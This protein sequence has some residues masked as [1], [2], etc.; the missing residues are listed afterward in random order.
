MTL[1][2]ISENISLLLLSLV[3]FFLLLSSSSAF[4]SSSCFCPFFSPSTLLPLSSY[5]CHSS[6]FLSFSISFSFS[7]LPPICPSS[8]SSLA[9]VP[10]FFCSTLLFSSSFLP[11][12]HEVSSFPHCVILLHSSY[13]AT[14][15]RS[16]HE[17]KLMKLCIKIINLSAFKPFSSDSDKN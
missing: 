6:S 5:L 2:G 16:N 8:S 13:F 7:P 12:Y 14:V 10:I 3:L 11:G 17:L 4:P 1:K 15:L 9:Y